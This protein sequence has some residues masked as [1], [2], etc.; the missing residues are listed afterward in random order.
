VTLARLVRWSGPACVAAGVLAVATLVLFAVVVGSGTISEAATSPAFY[1]PTVAALGSTVLLLVGLVGLFVRQAGELG[2]LGLAGFL[3]GLV[4]TALAAG[5]QWTYV[6]VL[7][8]LAERAP[9]LADASSGSVVAGFMLSYLVM[10]AGWLLFAVASLK[11]RVFPRWAVALLIVGAVVTLLP[12]PSRTLLLGVA[13]AC[14][15]VTLV[16][17]GRAADPALASRAA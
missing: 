8:Y 15:G 9:A 1:A 6:F 13:V 12:M 4:G 10:A 11:T 16:R 14:L 2:T 5:G 17:P 7:P 3:V